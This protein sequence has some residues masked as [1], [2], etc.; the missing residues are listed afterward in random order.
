MEIPRFTPA[1]RAYWGR[2]N[3]IGVR[4]CYDEG[5]RCACAAR[6]SAATCGCWSH[7]SRCVGGFRLPL[8]GTPARYSPPGPHTKN[9]EQRHHD[10]LPI[11]INHRSL[12]PSVPA[13]RMRSSR[14]APFATSARD[15]MQHVRRHAAICRAWAATNFALRSQRRVHFSGRVPIA[16]EPCG[17]PRQF[18][19]SGSVFGC[20]V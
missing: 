2:V 4:S 16:F 10:D 7:G 9:Q 15:G 20:A 13:I 19:W 14:P 3:P 11:D 8:K 5:K 12:H 6:R 1:D 17:L 18:S